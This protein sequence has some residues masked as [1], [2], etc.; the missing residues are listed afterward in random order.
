MILLQIDEKT[1]GKDREGLMKVFSDNGVQARPAWA[2]IHLQKPYKNYQSFNIQKTKQL[3]N[4]SLCI[5]SSTNI[6]TK[7]LDKVIISLNRSWKFVI[8]IKQAFTAIKGMIKIQ[9][10]MD[11]AFWILSILS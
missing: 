2:P 4:N 9:I 8:I 1:Y 5:P 3:V 6:S 10:L 11:L 7:N